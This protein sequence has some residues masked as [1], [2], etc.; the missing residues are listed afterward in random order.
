MN[1]WTEARRFIATAVLID[2][3]VIL[4]LWAVH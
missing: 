2:A 3:A 4:A 1:T